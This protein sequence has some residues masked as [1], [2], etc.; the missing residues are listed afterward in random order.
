MSLNI[1][2]YNSKSW[3]YLES[4]HYSFIYKSLIV[5]ILYKINDKDDG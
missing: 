2:I 1:K 4:L 3:L 5:M